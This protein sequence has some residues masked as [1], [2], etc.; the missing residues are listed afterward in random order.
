MFMLPAR[1][2]EA[3][4]SFLDGRFCTKKYRRSAFLNL[5]V[6]K[7]S[8]VGALTTNLCS[9]AL[10]LPSAAERVASDL[11]RTVHRI[12]LKT[13]DDDIDHRTSYVTRQSAPQG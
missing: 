6:R 7:K 9:Q 3:L 5:L 2:R 11:L 12:G 13:F 10:S 4:L 1:N 8:F